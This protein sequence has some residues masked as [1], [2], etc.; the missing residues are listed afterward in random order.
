[1]CPALGEHRRD[2]GGGARRDRNFACIPSYSVWSVLFIALGAA[3]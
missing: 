2:R 1:V 3:A